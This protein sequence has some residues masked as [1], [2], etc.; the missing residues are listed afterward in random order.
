MPTTITDKRARFSLLWVFVMLNMIYADILT[1]M[2]AGTLKDILAGHVGQIEF[3]PNFLL[4]AAVMTEVPIAMVVL[5]LVL[6]Q[7]AARWANIGA[8]VFTIA[9]IWGMGSASPHYVFIAGI[10]TLACMILA[11]KAWTWRVPA[12][13]VQ[14]EAV[15]AE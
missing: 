12:A 14:A 8:A 7:R 2:M 1:F 10:E 11:W 5:S 9:Y 6:P 4:L 15:L 3:T 13:S